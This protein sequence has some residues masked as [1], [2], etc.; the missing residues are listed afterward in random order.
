MS[1]K[2]IYMVTHNEVVRL[3]NANNVSQAIR[4]AAKDVIVARVAKQ[5]DIV[6]AL[7]AG[8]VLEDCATDIDTKD[9]FE[10]DDE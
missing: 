8:A 5:M 1:T 7:Q 2:R 6:A 10:G 9:M 4:H 3:V